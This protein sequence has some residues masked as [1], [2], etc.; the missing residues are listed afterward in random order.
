MLRRVLPVLLLPA[1]LL[2]GC[3]SGE[4]DDTEGDP[5]P[6]NTGEDSAV[7]LCEG[8]APVVTD[9]VV[10]NNGLYEFEGV[11]SPSMKVSV[12][13]TDAD[14]DLDLMDVQLWW[15]DVVDGAVDTSVAGARGG[16]IKMDEPCTTAE[17]TY[18]LIFQVEG[19]RFAYATAYEFA[20][21]AYDAAGLVSA[22]VVAHGVTPRED[23]SDG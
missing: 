22:Q 13:A 1:A 4:K 5:P 15:D 17:A 6:I 11:V 20:G 10:S 21:E 9:L 8:T 2:I 14:S 3:T 7:D 12:T 19:G 23:G 16:Y 18:G